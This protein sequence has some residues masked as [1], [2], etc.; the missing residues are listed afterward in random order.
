MPGGSFTKAPPAG[1]A[2]SAACRVLNFAASITAAGSWAISVN[3]VRIINSNDNSWGLV[4][5][6]VKSINREATRKRQSQFLKFKHTEICSNGSALFISLFLLCRHW[7]RQLKLVLA[8]LTNNTGF[9]T[10]LTSN[11]IPGTHLNTILFRNKPH[12]PHPVD[13]IV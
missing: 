5:M 4:F 11:R 9:Y 8:A 12:D 1:T 13:A 2:S 7:V 6:V 10:Q 3:C